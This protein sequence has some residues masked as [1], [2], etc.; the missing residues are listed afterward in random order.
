MTWVLIGLVV[1][2]LVGAALVIIRRRAASSDDMPLP[3]I[4]EPVDYTSIPTEEPKSLTDQLDSLRDRF[5]NIPLPAKIAMFA[6]PLVVIGLVILVVVFRSFV[7]SNPQAILPPPTPTPLP[8]ITVNKADLVNP[9]TIRVEARTTFP[10]GTEVHIDL[11]AGG[12]PFAWYD[13]A[14]GVVK[15][16]SGRVEARLNKAPN[17]PKPSADVTYTIRLHATT[18]DGQA[19]QQDQELDIPEL[20]RAAFFQ[21][22]P[23]SNPPV[24]DEPTPEPTPTMEQPAEEPTPEPTVEPTVAPSSELVATVANGGNVRGVPGGEP[25][26]DQVNANETVVL[27][28]KNATGEWYQLRNE[29]NNVGWVHHS[30]LTID[31]AVAEQVPVEGT[32]DVPVPTLPAPT[33]A[34]TVAPPVVGPT[35][36]PTEPGRPTPTPPPSTGLTAVFPMAE[37]CGGRRVVIQCWTRS[38]RARQ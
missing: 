9:N 4:G 3:D 28:Q 14:E 13:P 26:I 10:D 8:S 30:L 2:L 29:R 1:V 22:Q 12:E 18:A 32:A 16:A 15:V 37:T 25:I 24:S 34:A 21:I 35:E 19:V 38:T 11:L 36:E 23:A 20:H 5:D 31:P 7:P 6:A 33:E 27:L 17:A